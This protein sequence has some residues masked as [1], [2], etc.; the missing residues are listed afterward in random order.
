MANIINQI[1]KFFNPSSVLENQKAVEQIIKEKLEELES[2]A[3]KKK[4]VKK[5]TTKKTAKKAPAKKTTAKKTATK[6]K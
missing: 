6:K 4:A 1:K 5:T 2:T 3:P